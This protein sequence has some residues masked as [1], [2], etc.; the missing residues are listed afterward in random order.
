MVALEKS[1]PDEKLV[2]P[3]QPL[4]MNVIL[5]KLA[6]IFSDSNSPDGKLVTPLQPKNIPYVIVALVKLY[7]GTDV[8][9][10]QL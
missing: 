9:E 10:V 1:H 3:L 8:I 2:T 4:N 6:E 7:A 5:V